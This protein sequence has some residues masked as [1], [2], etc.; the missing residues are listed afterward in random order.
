MA[1]V[2]HIVVCRRF[3]CGTSLPNPEHRYNSIE[4]VTY[5]VSIAG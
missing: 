2:L 3:A 1:P 5:D 4:S